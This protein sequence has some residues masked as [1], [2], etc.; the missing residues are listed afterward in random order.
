MTLHSAIWVWGG[1]VMLALFALAFLFFIHGQGMVALGL[2]FGANVIGILVWL[3][4]TSF[5]RAYPPKE[6]K[7]ESGPPLL[8]RLNKEE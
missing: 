3:L 6:E 4:A 1:T 2:F 7:E 5:R 8:D